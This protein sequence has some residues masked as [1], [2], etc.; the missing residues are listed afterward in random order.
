VTSLRNSIQYKITKQLREELG[1]EEYETED[2]LYQIF[3]NFRLSPNNVTGLRLS[4]YGLKIMKKVY[5]YYSYKIKDIK[6][7]SNIVIKMDKV[8]KFPYYVDGKQM[9]L[10]SGKDAFMLKLRGNDFNKWLKSLK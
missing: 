3:K 5:D 10:F 4:P 7:T 1:I 8:M 2:L 9:V 6:I